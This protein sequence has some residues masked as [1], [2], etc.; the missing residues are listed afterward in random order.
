LQLSADDLVSSIF[1]DI[2]QFDEIATQ[3]KQNEYYQPYII[4]V[5]QSKELEKLGV[6]NLKEALMLVPGVDM[7]TDNF[8]N[9]TAIFRGSNPFAYGQSKLLIDGVL[10]NNLFFD[11]YSEYLSM[12]IDM[13]KRIEIVRGPGS[14][15]DGINA[16]AGSI[17]VVTYA[18]D[19]NDFESN[20]KL[21]FKYGSYDY[22]MG[23]FVKNFKT[24]NFK[25][26][27]DFYY[28]KDDKK[29]ASGPDGL[30][31]GSLGGAN[32]GLSQSG[33]APL[34]LQEYSL[35]LNMEYKEFSLKAR[36]LQ[37][38]QGSAYGINLAL[39]QDNDR[40]KLPSYYAELGYIKKINAFKI[41]IK[42]G[43]KYDAF[44]SKAKLAPDGVNLSG[45]VFPDGGYGEH[46]AKQRVLYQSTY[47][48]YSG[49]QKHNITLGYRMT[50]EKTID[51]RSKL[52]NLNTGDAA[53]VDYTN[54]LPFFD[55]DAKRNI[56]AF[57]LQDA[58]DVN[59]K[60]S[61]LY[62]INYE[63]TS[64]K[65]AGFE[66]RVSLVYRKD[67]KNIFKA[68]YS[69]SHRNPSW[70]EMFTKNNHARVCSTNLKP[71]KVT[72]YELAYIRNFSNDAYLQANAFYLLNKN[73]IYNS[74]INP[75][76]RNSAKTDIYGIEIEL[77]GHILPN[78]KVYM[79][80]T[81]LDGIYNVNDGSGNHSLP[82]VSHHLAKGYYIYNFNSFISLGT[83]VKYISAKERIADDLRP[84]VKAYT[85]VDTALNYKNSQYNYTIN[86]S[87]KNLFDANVRYSSP[88]N[89][90]IDDYKQEGRTFLVTLKK[91]F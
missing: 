67:F 8:N 52:S 51:M 29:I 55:K 27:I 34:W 79:N 11:A 56:F 65:D 43:I 54:T 23:G 30:S 90:Y 84:K 50:Q 18:E 39:P 91:R 5:F 26:H 14:K 33:E 16:Y 75:V 83:T 38:K 7:A 74:A 72:S 86:I 19:V 58:Y 81:Y 57:S 42:A 21:V 66:P 9:Q 48:K 73:Q 15:F 35:G 6:C 68:I 70:Q 53:L 63:Q 49:V 61:L 77:K 45:V 69:T 64:Y 47:L 44:D 4:S 40:V 76:Y 12:P 60:L 32:V 85:T 80:Y 89:T 62:G 10:V 28:Q 37:H 1:T 82:N 31:Q 24:K 20:D 25:T 59:D 22:K 36:V 87:V 88:P 71:E 78:D 13:I 2:Q 41:D 17:N 46:Y 3:T